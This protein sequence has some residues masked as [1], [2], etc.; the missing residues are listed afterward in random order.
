M[1]NMLNNL[2]LTILCLL[3]VFNSQANTP[4]K[5][6]E[7]L[8]ESVQASLQSMLKNMED[9]YAYGKQKNINW[10]CLNQQYKNSI[11]PLESKTDVV[12]FFEHL[13]LEFAD[14]H[15]TLN[16]NTSKSYRLNSP[17]FVKKHQSA[18]LI[19]DFWQTQLINSTKLTIGA[20]L[21]SINGKTVNEVIK[22]FPT[23]CLDK[24]LTGNQ[25]WIVNKSLAGKYSESR[26]IQV[27][28]GE[29]IETIDMDQLQYQQHDNLLNTEVINKFGVIKINNSLGQT[30]LIT[31]FDQAIDEL[32]STHGLILDLRN[33]IN[34]GD[35]YVARAIIGRFIDRAQPYQKHR[36]E[37]H[38]NGGPKVP[39]IWTEYT[40]P[41]ET[42]YNKPLVVLVNQWTGSMGEGLTIGLHGIQRAQIIGSQMAGLLGAVYGFQLEGT[43]FGYQM[44]SEQ[45]F[46]IDNTPREMFIPDIVVKPSPDQSDAVLNEGVNWLKQRKA[47]H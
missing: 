19:D 35:S 22:N 38:R 36:F 6:F 46:H 3:I 14:S 31:A 39:R 45:L 10:V 9:N 44:P 13:L 20:E 28:A 23:H 30:G 21:I 11:I 8:Q 42:I 17:I 1:K 15:M 4:T 26:I 24:S 7:A 47:A 40:S 27:K 34:G 16:T 18:F 41:R 2:F 33:T 12:L 32:K 43:G 29:N 37:E 25:Q 5:D